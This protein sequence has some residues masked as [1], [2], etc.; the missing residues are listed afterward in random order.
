MLQPAGLQ[1]VGHAWAT[2]KQL[3]HVVFPILSQEKSHHL[4][5][6]LTLEPHNTK[7]HPSLQYCVSAVILG[8]AD[9]FEQD[10]DF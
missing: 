1:R 6:R 10:F 2:E 5:L 3:P 8:D 4:R 7:R 9:L